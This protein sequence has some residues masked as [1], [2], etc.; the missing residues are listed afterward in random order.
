MKAHWLIVLLLFVASASLASS[1]SAPYRDTLL[2]AIELR[3]Q[4]IRSSGRAPADS[5]SLR[6]VIMAATPDVLATLTPHL[7]PAGELHARLERARMT[8]DSANNVHSRN[9]A[10]LAKDI[11]FPEPDPLSECADASAS[12]AHAML[13]AWSVSSEVLAAAK[14]ACLQTEVGLNGAAFC[15][16]LA[17]ETEAL[18]TEYELESFCLG[19]QRDATMAAAA[20]TQQNVADFLN[21]RADTTLSSRATQVSVDNLQTTL[22][23]LQTRLNNLRAALNGDGGAIALGLS[24]ILDDAA[25]LATQLETL[26]AAIQNVRFRIQVT[27]I[28][29]VDAQGRLADA[30]AQMASVLGAAAQLRTHLL[31]IQSELIRAQ[32]A[33]QIAAREQRDRSLAAALGDPDR[34]VIRYRLPVAN[35][36]ELERSREILIRALA[37]Y[38]TLGADTSAARALLVTGDTAY[39]QGRPLDA[40][41]AFAH[42]YRL[43]LGAQMTTQIPLIARDSFE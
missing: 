33:Q 32:S 3:D 7:P 22:A 4:A 35:G 1:D 15:T 11:T 36:G 23:S 19:A 9:P 2:A 28:N 42:A 8:L 29:I 38:E 13:E 30:Q 21:E 27:Q 40:Y 20:Q 12:A 6:R 25:A 24:N 31:V 43:L 16:G 41:D 14:W 34:V 10:A 18:E 39:N 17:I 37:A 5:E 26:S